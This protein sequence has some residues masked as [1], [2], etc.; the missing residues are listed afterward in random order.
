MG[1]AREQYDFRFVLSAGFNPVWYDTLRF[2]I[3]T[4]EIALI[5]FVVEDY[6]KTS[7]NDFV[8]QYVLPLRCMQQGKLGEPSQTRI[9]QHNFGSILR[10]F[11]RGRQNSRVGPTHESQECQTYNVT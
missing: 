9:R 6:D 4:P 7:K 5:R 8:G 11:C 10:L 3:R 1:F 2:T